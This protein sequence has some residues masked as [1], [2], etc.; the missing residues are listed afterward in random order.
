LRWST[1]EDADGSPIAGAWVAVAFALVG[2]ML[3]LSHLMVLVGQVAAFGPLDMLAILAYA[4]GVALTLIGS[5]WTAY[6]RTMDAQER[7]SIGT[8]ELS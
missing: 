8:D 1:D 3:G 6:E 7:S 5:V 4:V 2:T